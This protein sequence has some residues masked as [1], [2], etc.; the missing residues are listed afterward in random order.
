MNVRNLFR[1]LGVILTLGSLGWLFT[2]QA[3]SR[4]KIIALNHTVGC[5]PLHLPLILD[6]KGYYQN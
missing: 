1:V 3:T 2:P 5:D 4:G 6:E